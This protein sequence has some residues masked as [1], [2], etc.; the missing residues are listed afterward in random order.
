MAGEQRVLAVEDGPLDGVGIDLD[1]PVV[2]EAALTK[3]VNLW[4]ASRIDELMPWAYVRPAPAAK[5]G[6]ANRLR[7]DIAPKQPLNVRHVG[8]DSNNEIEAG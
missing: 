7:S 5:V 3:L 8:D 2:G 4:P 6:R 1:A